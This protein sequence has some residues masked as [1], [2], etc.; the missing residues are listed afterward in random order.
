LAVHQENLKEK[1]TFGA[2][3]GTVTR[4]GENNGRALALNAFSNI[5]PAI[6]A[7]CVSSGEPLEGEGKKNVS[8]PSLRLAQLCI[9]LVS[10]Q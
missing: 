3:V 1:I 7:Q 8:E 9:I 5:S 2:L 6:A 4:G 10:A